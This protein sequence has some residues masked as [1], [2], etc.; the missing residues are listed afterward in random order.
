MLTR[1]DIQKAEMSGFKAIK[2]LAKKHDIKANGSA[3]SIVTRLTEAADAAQ[4]PAPTTD[5][6]TEQ[7]P[8]PFNVHPT[9]TAIAGETVVVYYISDTASKVDIGPFD[10]E[11][12]AITYRDRHF[13]AKTKTGRKS[14]INKTASEPGKMTD[15]YAS[16]VVTLVALPGDGDKLAKQAE[17]IIELIRAAALE[18]EADIEGFTMTQGAVVEALI[19][20]AAGPRE[21]CNTTQSPKRIWDF[22]RKPL[23]EAGYITVE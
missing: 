4:A 18:A 10:T 8:E 13:T 19:G 3:A 14:N 15:K 2:A 5:A 17:G 16:K 11:D 22:Y 9:E 6:P 21:F 23:I 20:D 1:E 12:Q 7:A